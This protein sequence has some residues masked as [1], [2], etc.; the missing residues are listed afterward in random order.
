[1]NKESKEQHRENPYR[2]L[3]DLEN[4]TKYIKLK[5]EKARKEA[6]AEERKHKIY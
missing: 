3:R 4:N 1:M 5:T 6:E 2:H